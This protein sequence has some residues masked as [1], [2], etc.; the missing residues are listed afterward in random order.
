MGYSPFEVHSTL[1]GKSALLWIELYHGMSDTCGP[2]EG[3]LH[4]ANADALVELTGSR[5]HASVNKGRT[6]ARVDMRI[7]KGLDK[8][9]TKR[10]Y[11]RLIFVL[12]LTL[13]DKG[14]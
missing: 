14:R 5:H 12:L 10:Q 1:F 11:R 13:A 4:V 3:R 9:M 8:H 7:P 2:K 6:T